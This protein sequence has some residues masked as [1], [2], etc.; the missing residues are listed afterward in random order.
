MKALILSALVVS[1]LHCSCS[2]FG[3][4]SRSLGRRPPAQQLATASSGSDGAEPSSQIA[5]KQTNSSSV[6]AATFSLIKA[7]V[8]SGVLTLPAGLAVTSDFPSAL[9]PGSFLIFLL[10]SLS[11]YTFSLYGRL[12]HETQARSLGELWAA[13][14]RKQESA[15]TKHS[16]IAVANLVY[17]LGVNLTFL[18][19]IGDTLSSLLSLTAPNSSWWTSRQVSIVAVTSGLLWPLCNL[20]SLSALAPVSLV[21]VI[22]TFLTTAFMGWRCPAL[23]PNSPYAK[24]GSGF[25]SAKDAVP[26]PQFRSYSRFATP[27]PLVLTA[28]A[29]VALMAH[30]SA[31]DFYHSLSDREALNKKPQGHKRGRE[32]LQKFNLM[33][34]AGYLAVA[35]VNILTLSFG[36]LTFGSGSA[37]IVLNNYAASDKGAL[38]SRIFTLTSV[39]GGF[40]LLLRAAKSSALDLFEKVS[41]RAITLILLS[42]V[43]FFSLVLEDAGFVVGF[44][45]AI[46]GAA[47]VYIFP[48]LLF[49][50]KTADA[51]INTRAV[52]IE[53]LFCKFLVAF[54]FVSAVIGGSTTVIA[55]FLPH[56]LH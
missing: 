12:T 35:I 13:I 26:M 41:P 40:P 17:C 24:I 33:T 23:F 8:G 52:R 10:G 51:P 47:I 53:R 39:I 18:L 15:N 19:V 6:S 29:C 55:S 25:L 22:G 45:G 16:V 54:G 28:M 14:Q 49:L 42:I 32:T 56:I 46:M 2:A 1:S 7:M 5:N 50:K 21:G 48:C 9:W 20:S 36:F 34:V 30:F 38:I 27:A 4:I 11:A 3:S 31:P 43:T 44:N 37:G